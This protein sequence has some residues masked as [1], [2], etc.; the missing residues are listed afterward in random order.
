MPNARR[1]TEL[2]LDDLLDRGALAERLRLAGCVFAEDEA[3][4]LLTTATTPDE[5]EQM[6]RQ[7]V[8]G[9]PLEQIVGWAEFGGLRI[10]VEPGVFVPRRRTEL[11]LHQA[12]RLAPP[13]PVIVELCCGSGALALAVASTLPQVELYATD[14]DPAAVRCAG[15]NLA[16]LAGVLQ[17]DL[18]EPLPTSLV[19]RIDLLLA[20]APYVPTGSIPLM[21]PEARLYEPLVALDGGSDGLD[22]QRRIIAGARRWLAPNGRLLVETSRSQASASV[23]AFEHHGLEAQV[24]ISDELDATVVVG[25]PVAA[26]SPNTSWEVEH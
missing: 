7:R 24:V 23:A 9:I 21:P 20:N 26:G 17:G 11:L 14:I 2:R 8:R 19:G 5:L 25:G 10:A 13:Q 15:R 1:T 3:E 12:P 18:F 4:L 6:V 22:V 16:G